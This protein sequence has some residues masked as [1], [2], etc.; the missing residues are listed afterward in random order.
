SFGTASFQLRRAPGAFAAWGEVQ[1]GD[2]AIALDTP[3]D[4]RCARDAGYDATAPRLSFALP[5][6]EVHDA[7]RAG[8]DFL[9]GDVRQAPGWSAPARLPARAHWG[10]LRPRSLP[11]L[12]REWVAP[13]AL[14]GAFALDASEALLSFRVPVPDRSRAEYQAHHL[15]FARTQICSPRAQSVPLGL[16]WG[17]Y[18]VNGRGP[19][20]SAGLGPGQRNRN[21]IWVDLRA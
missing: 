4:W 9:G 17:S 1:A 20:K 10:E 2:A 21:Q 6:M 14:S 15:L 13:K 8:V 7:R 19:L 12:T 3:G 18:Y 11:P 16:W 5:P